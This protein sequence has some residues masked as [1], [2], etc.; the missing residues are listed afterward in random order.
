MKNL[1]IAVTGEIRSGKDTV[2]SLIQQPGT[3]KLYFAEGIELIIKTFFPE[4]FDGTKKP[5]SYYQ[6]IGQ[7]M[8]TINPMVWINYTARKFESMKQQGVSTFLCTD[9]RQPNEYQWLKDNGFIVIKVEADSEIR[10]QRMK[11]SG[12]KFDLQDLV[13]PVEQEIKRLPYDFL[14]DNNEGLDELASQV[15]AVM[16]EV[17]GGCC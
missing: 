14:I 4:A 10:I 12:D 1:R 2:C 5:R 6:K 16:N 15:A 8:R 11:E 13:H 9:L 3:G 17:K 7:F